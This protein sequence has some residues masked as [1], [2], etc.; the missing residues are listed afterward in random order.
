M[1]S[2]IVFESFST[3]SKATFDEI[4]RL[5][6]TTVDC[7]TCFI[8]DQDLR[9]DCELD[10][11]QSASDLRL[12]E[13]SAKQVRVLRQEESSGSQATAADNSSCQDY[14]RHFCKQAEH[15]VVE[16]S[17]GASK[18]VRWEQ[19]VLEDGSQDTQDAVPKQLSE[20]QTSSVT[21]QLRTLSRLTTSVCTDYA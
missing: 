21:R 1:S 10:E 6:T 14:Q 3:Q 8:K 13:E 4:T 18:R 2:C 15:L 17:A 7:Q 20:D 5:Q 11:C 16:V 19:G 9:R 12:D